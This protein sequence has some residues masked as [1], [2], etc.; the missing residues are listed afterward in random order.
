MV[1]PRKGWLGL[2]GPR[3]ASGALFA[4]GARPVADL[5]FGFRTGDHVGGGG[6]LRFRLRG[7]FH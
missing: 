2:F 7:Y 1:T 5:R 6:G 3:R 4:V